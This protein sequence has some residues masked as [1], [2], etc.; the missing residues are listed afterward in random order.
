MNLV[1]LATLMPYNPSTAMARKGC[2]ACGRILLVLWEPL[3][4]HSGVSSYYGR[5]EDAGGKFIAVSQDG[6]QG[7]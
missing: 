4:A 1:M 5:S 6:R 7:R 3:R 2:G